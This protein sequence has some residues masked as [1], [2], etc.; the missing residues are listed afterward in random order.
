MTGD[1]K[2]KRCLV[3][4]MRPRQRSADVV[5]VTVDQFD[6]VA[7]EHPQEM[8]E[9]VILE[10]LVVLRACNKTAEN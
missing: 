1:L 6:P 4:F 7:V 5:V 3:P 2:A 8:F 10:F 9:K